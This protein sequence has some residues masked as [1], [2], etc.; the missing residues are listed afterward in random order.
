MVSLGN[1]KATKGTDGLSYIQK[2][3]FDFNSKLESMMAEDEALSSKNKENNRESVNSQYREEVKSLKSKLSELQKYCSALEVR[4]GDE[5]FQTSG[6]NTVVF[7][8]QERI[9]E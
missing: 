4:V 2:R 6:R 8:E 9:A 7:A 3:L 5:I 1:S